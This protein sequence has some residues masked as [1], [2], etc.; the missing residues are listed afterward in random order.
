M[1]QLPGLLMA[2]PDDDS[3]GVAGE[4]RPSSHSSV[5]STM[6]GL[7]A[8]GMG[9]GDAT[10]VEGRI[11][12]QPAYAPLGRRGGCCCCCCCEHEA[13]DPGR[14]YTAGVDEGSG[15]TIGSMFM[16]ASPGCC[17]GMNRPC[18]RLSGFGS[19]L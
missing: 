13:D 9:M 19:G 5:S 12:T 7:C 17:C 15:A 10:M 18:C 1:S 4:Y 14:E 16:G 8:M 2:L 6:A 3:G 11:G